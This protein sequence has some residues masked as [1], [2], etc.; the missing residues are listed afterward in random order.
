MLQL[1]YRHVIRTRF[2]ALEGWSRARWTCR[3]VCLIQ[4][5]LYHIPASHLASCNWIYCALMQSYCVYLRNTRAPL[6]SSRIIA[7][8]VVICL[9]I[10]HI[11]MYV[12][13]SIIALSVVNVYIY[14]Y[15]YKYICIVHMYMFNGPFCVR[16]IDLYLYTYM[17]LYIIAPFVWDNAFIHVTPPAPMNYIKYLR[18]GHR[19]NAF[20]NLVPRQYKSFPPDRFLSGGNQEHNWVE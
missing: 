16:W 5:R 20:S 15:I 2:R 9:Y 11:Y 14:I 6:L 7:P 8:F 1:L 12:H 17:C 10:K 13:V 19:R 4:A 3:V 18:A